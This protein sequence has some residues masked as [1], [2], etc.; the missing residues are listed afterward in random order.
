M[1]PLAT[2]AFC[3]AL[4]LQTFFQFPG[5]TWLQQD[6]QIYVP[7][8][9]HLRDPGVLRNDIL[10]QH[11]HVAFTLY[12]E[13]ALGLRAVT[14]LGF[15]EVLGAQQIVTRALGIWGLLLMA[16]A[17]GLGFGLA[18][19]VAAI[20]SLG[21][22]I[23]GPAV[24]T[25]EYEPTPRA[26]AVPLLV[27][28]IGLAAR[29]R[30]LGAGV[31]AVAAFLYHP[32]T[33]LPFWGVYLLLVMWPGEL[34]RA[35]AMALLPL[36]AGASLLWVAARTQSAA[37][38]AQR[39][40]ERLESGQEFLQR[41]RAAYV[42]V[43]TWPSATIAH[44][45]LVLAILAAAFMRVRRALNTELRVLVLG[46]AAVGVLS[47][48]GS[49]LLLEEWH[50]GLVPQIQPMRALLFLT[51]GMLF[52]CAAAGARALEAGRRVD[53]MGWLACALVLPLQPVLTGPYVWSRVGLAV[54]LA[55]ITAF[56]GVRLA[57]VPA[58][59]AFLVIPV[60]GGVVNYPRL[61]TADL[62]ELSQWARANTSR[63]AV[64]VFPDVNKGLAPGIFRSE[65]LRAVY[66]DWKGGGQ[67]NYLKDLGEQWWF[68][69]QQTRNFQAS[70]MAQYAASGVRYVVVT[71]PL[72]GQADFQNATYR[73][74]RTQ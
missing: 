23:S 63:D 32:P 58:M 61:H 53:A 74:Y 56:A 43:S 2:A 60:V 22:L 35:R 10:V 59:A 27:C 20:C 6:S 4:A 38:D 66:V 72:A 64:F 14:G 46:L 24:L 67:V 9:E 21:A 11:P 51:L 73:V 8:L 49:W 12:D 39:V 71:K 45:L 16:E 30:F 19:M 34:R 26:F 50:W 3:V 44:H 31:T 1:K 70:M 17:L 40:F 18:L 7:I 25:L 57:L 42:W 65:A 48:P 55:A 68:R 15:R 29:R 54:A 47:M 5:H 36:V 13:V 28:A 52:L 62:A 37:G 33:A 69:W 41:F